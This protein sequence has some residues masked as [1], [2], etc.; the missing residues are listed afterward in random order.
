MCPRSLVGKGCRQ[1]EQSPTS[2][3][4]AEHCWG[5]KEEPIQGMEKSYMNRGL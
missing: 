5:A 3:R 2:V 4:P 1:A